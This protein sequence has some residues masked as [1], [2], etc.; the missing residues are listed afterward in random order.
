MADGNLGTFAPQEKRA[1]LRAERL[2]LG[3]ILLDGEGTRAVLPKVRPV[4][5]ARDFYDARHATLFEVFCALADRRERIDIVTTCAELRARHRLNAVTAQYVGELTDGQFT[6]ALAEDH[7][8]IVATE[9]RARRTRDQMRANAE[10]IDRG[11]SDFDARARDVSRVAASGAGDDDLAPIGLTADVEEDRLTGGGAMGRVP[12][13]LSVLDRALCGGFGDRDMVVV[14]ACSSVGKSALVLQVS[15]HV[16]ETRGL[17]VLYFSLEM[18]R[19]ALLQRLACQRARVSLASAIGGT[20][21][22]RE[23]LR[24]AEALRAVRASRLLVSDKRGQTASTLRTRCLAARAAYGAIG[25]VVVDY[26]QRVRADRANDSREREVAA[27]SEVIQ[28]LPTEIECPVFAVCALNRE[29]DKR[30]GRPRLSD[31][32]ESGAIGFDSDT[33]L[34]MWRENDDRTKPRIAIEKQ[35]NGPISDDIE[36]AWDTSGVRLIEPGA[37]LDPRF[38]GDAPFVWGDDAQ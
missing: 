29:A 20:M 9:G 19:L 22:D 24:Y 5:Q 37:D 2:L 33:A 35:R 4:V 12:S 11:A 1:D 36:L 14:A 7:A 18:P 38:T 8:R 10:D 27:I 13:G 28:T 23:M 21:T 25:G 26:L 6:V 31:L 3:A 16:A 17:P 15:D 32:R 34:V 30:K